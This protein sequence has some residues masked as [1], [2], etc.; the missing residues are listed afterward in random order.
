MAII[1]R[2]IWTEAFEPGWADAFALLALLTWCAGLAHAG[3]WAWLCHPD[4]HRGEIDRLYR[5][6]MEAYMQGRWEDSRRRLERILALDETDADVLLQLGTIHA[7][8]RQPTMA[9]RAFRQCLELEGGSKWRW[10]IEQAEA[11][12]GRP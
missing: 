7:R 10:E 9:R 8:L 4:R 5:D 3:W 2:W 1:A 6:A 11:R 12:L